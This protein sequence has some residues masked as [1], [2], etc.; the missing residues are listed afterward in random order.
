M[1]SSED[2]ANALDVEAARK[3]TTFSD[4]STSVFFCGSSCSSG[5]CMQLEEVEVGADAGP[6]QS[7]DDEAITTNEAR[8]DPREV[9][10]V[11]SDG[12]AD[13]SRT[14]LRPERLQ[15]DVHLA[16]RRLSSLALRADLQLTRIMDIILSLSMARR[17]SFTE[18]RTHLCVSYIAIDNKYWVGLSEAP[19]GGR[20][21]IGEWD[22]RRRLAAERPRSRTPC[23][24]RSGVAPS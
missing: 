14:Y 5:E 13:R 22:S 6:K 8:N 2:D 16:P 10:T 12:Q 20:A 21:K 7:A 9:E 24:K 19:C 15:V 4:G 18:R 1:T 23:R 11:Q 3:H 17:T